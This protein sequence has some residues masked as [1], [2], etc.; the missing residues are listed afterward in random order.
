MA[1]IF[2]TNGSIK[3]GCVV[4]IKVDSAGGQGARFMEADLFD[5]CLIVGFSTKR[6]E[7]VSIVKCFKDNSFI[8]AFGD[9]LDQSYLSVKAMCFLGGD[10]PKNK[11]LDNVNGFYNK[12]RISQSTTAPLHFYY[13]GGT[14]IQCY[15]LGM[16]TNTADVKYLLQEVTFRLL[17]LPNNTIVNTGGGPI[18]TRNSGASGSGGS[19]LGRF[20][21]F[22]GDVNLGNVGLG[23]P[24]IIPRIP[25]T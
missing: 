9:S 14:N 11:S 5:S 24:I 19:N 10:I 4:R 20:G 18:Y 7:S 2:S 8:Y 25:G 15:L 23:G 22:A 12:Y 6:E 21:G 16:E 13:G 1:V 3:R 17:M